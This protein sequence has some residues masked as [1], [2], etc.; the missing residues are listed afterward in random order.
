M[1]EDVATKGFFAHKF[2]NTTIQLPDSK[3]DEY[4]TGLSGKMGETLYLDKQVKLE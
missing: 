1:A 3:Y 2:R 4:M